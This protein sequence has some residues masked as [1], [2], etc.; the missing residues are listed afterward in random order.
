M[1]WTMKWMT[2]AGMTLLSVCGA[3]ASGGAELP[4]LPAVDSRDFA[5]AAKTAAVGSRL[6]LENV[7]VSDADPAA[8]VLERFEVF[9]Q[10]ATVTLHGAQGDRV[11]PA[12]AN[13]YFRGVIDGKPESH[14]FLAVLAD[15]STQGILE[16]ADATYLIGAEGA[17]AKALGGPLTMQRVDPVLL[18]SARN[19]GF[20]CANDQL[21][22]SNAHALPKGL[23]F[24]PATPAAP[25]APAA[26]ATDASGLPAVTAAAT[27]GVK[28]AIETDT[29]FLQLF[30]NNSTT[31]TNYI[32]NLIGYASTIYTAEINTGLAVQS[33]S[34]WTGG[35]DPWTQSDTQCGLMEFGKYWNVNKTNVPRTIAHFM[36]GKANGG[37]IAWVGVLCSGSFNTGA[38]S[39]CP[40]L[41]AESTPWGGGYGYTG[42]LSGTFNINSPTVVWDIDAVAHEIGHN[43]NSP[44]SHCYG[45]IG[46]NANPIDQCYSGEQGCYSGT[47]T[48]PGPSG[49]GSGTIMS[50]CHLLTP[51]MSN[52]K[53]TF[54]NTETFGVAPTRESS[55][56]SSYVVS[57]ATGGQAA[58][59]APVSSGAGI[60]SDGFEGGAVP[61]P[62][63]SKTP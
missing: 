15:G 41:G 34:L 25:V 16:D 42:N 51:G 26:G 33:V 31:A 60:F 32:G 12:P 7:A 58:C 4:A 50:Y 59:L 53:L 45:G 8:L 22:P 55:R 63:S 61:G 39:I 3:A 17:P 47:P 43:F 37:G 24:T 28:V 11:V 49:S 52:I 62:W 44:H 36:S 6:R 48:L 57:L 30:G 21:L 40:A 27:Y 10:G 23:D 1:C 20:R 29:E 18:K 19:S 35:T 56:M 46:G 14:A 9:A 38:A 2:L 5:G 54:G 13:A